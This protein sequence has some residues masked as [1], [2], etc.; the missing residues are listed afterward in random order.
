MDAIEEQRFY[1]S[2]TANKFVLIT[3]A[4]FFECAV[5]TTA[6]ISIEVQGRRVNL[7]EKNARRLANEIL[8]LL[9]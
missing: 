3:N 1:D 4:P 6:S 9:A 5:D 2:E 8:K 7:E